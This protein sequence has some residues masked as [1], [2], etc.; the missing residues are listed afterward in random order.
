M[1]TS[2]S[3]EPG[4]RPR[5]IAEL[6]GLA[7]AMEAEAMARY[8]Q[9]AAEMERQGDAALAATF[10]AMLEEERR[11]VA[12]VTAWSVAATGAAPAA[13]QWELPSEI[14][15]SWE[16]VAGSALLTPYR[17]LAV[18]VL[19]EERG[20]AFYSYIAA[21]AADAGTRIA[22]ERLAS[23]ELD[24]AA[25]LRRLRRRAYHREHPAIRPAFPGNIGEKAFAR[26]AA[27]AEAKAGAIHA[28][29]AARLAA[30]GDGESAAVLEAVAAAEREAAAGLPGGI[31]STKS[32]PPA[33]NTPASLLREALATSEQLHDA[34]AD[35]LEHAQDDTARAQAERG[36][37]RV[38]Q[39]LALIAA[40]LHAPAR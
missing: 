5:G 40:R 21:H 23:E 25:A 34:Y 4:A 27:V 30:L 29:L 11:H 10:R 39:Q 31:R 22:A 9:L 28:R 14:A 2:L 19:N 33:A 7:A 12:Q 18:A 13:V 37:T 32:L 20:F 26:Q 17:A 1:R 35:T 24:H 8:A 15:R 38:A 6:M 16:D 36:A 3:E